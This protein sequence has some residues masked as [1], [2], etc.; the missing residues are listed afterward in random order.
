MRSLTGG[1]DGKGNL[2]SKQSSI[3]VFIEQWGRKEICAI[4][5][6]PASQVVPSPLG[7]PSTCECP[8]KAKGRKK[9]N[10]GWG[11]E[12]QSSSSS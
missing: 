7:M 6:V 12:D 10:G 8:Q 9:K 5:G 4:G 3:I 2:E 11:K 1:G